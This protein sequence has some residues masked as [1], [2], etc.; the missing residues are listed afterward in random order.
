MVPLKLAFLLPL[1]VLLNGCVQPITVIGPVGEPVDS[2]EVVIYYPQR[3]ECNFETIGYISIGGGY[4]SLES[5]FREMRMQ[6][7]SL[8][9]DA[10]YVLHTQRL[11]IKE[12]IGSAK[13]IRCD[14]I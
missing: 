5:L 14:A 6:A 9:A 10:I 12:Y 1:T 11:D 8:G 2:S 4:Y 7:A 13:A 3:P